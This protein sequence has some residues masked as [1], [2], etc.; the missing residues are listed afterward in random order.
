ME[1]LFPVGISILFTVIILSV[2]RGFFVWLLKIN[3]ILNLL[4]KIADKN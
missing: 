2:L 1:F 3:D 4:K